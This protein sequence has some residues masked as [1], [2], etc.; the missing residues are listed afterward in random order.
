MEAHEVAA[1]LQRSREQL[2]AE[3]FS[4]GDPEGSLDGLSP[5]SAIM[6]FLLAPERRGLV[7][8]GLGAAFAIAGRGG[9]L[10]GPI[11][12]G[13]LLWS[14]LGMTRSRRR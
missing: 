12:I 6:N 10:A 9:A 8:A 2:R 3:L 13:R 7:L 11:G 5:R 4:T 14:L 1:S